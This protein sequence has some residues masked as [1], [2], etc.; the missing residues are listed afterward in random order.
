MCE[1]ELDNHDPVIKMVGRLIP[2]ENADFE[3]QAHQPE[4][5][6]AL[7]PG[8]DWSQPPNTPVSFDLDATNCT[9]L[10]VLIEDKADV[11]IEREKNTAVSQKMLNQMLTVKMQSMVRHGLIPKKLAKCQIPTFTSCSNGRATR[12]E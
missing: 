3:E 8:V 7:E 2:D 1:E 4:V 11:I 12:R 5:P 9:D 6:D 10:P